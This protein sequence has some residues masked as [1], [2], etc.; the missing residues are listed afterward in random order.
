[1]FLLVAGIAE[2]VNV[3]T[4]L[5]GNELRWFESQVTVA[6]CFQELLPSDTGLWVRIPLELIKPSTHFFDSLL[7]DVTLK[8][9]AAFERVYRVASLGL[10]ESAM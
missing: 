9:C 5:F 6:A 1:M 3:I 10:V 8:G 7:R 2:H 4:V